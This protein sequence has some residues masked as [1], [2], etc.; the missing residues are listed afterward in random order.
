MVGEEE[1]RA[2]GQTVEARGHNPAGQ[3]NK[4]N[5][6]VLPFQR[7]EL[8]RPVVRPS[9]TC[10]LPLVYPDSH[11][12][13]AGAATPPSTALLSP[14]PEAAPDAP[15]AVPSRQALMCTCHNQWAGND[16]EDGLE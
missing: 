2:A 9:P 14:S 10:S 3:S 1:M 4:I 12:R 11:L 15:G 6:Q 7:S 8:P 16:P 13:P 5:D